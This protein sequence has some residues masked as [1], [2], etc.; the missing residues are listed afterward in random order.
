MKLFKCYKTEVKKL[1]Q[2]LEQGDKAI[3]ENQNLSLSKGTKISSIAI[4]QSVNTLKNICKYK[5]QFTYIVNM[6]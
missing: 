5:R 1:K 2:G 3:C 4:V 6:P